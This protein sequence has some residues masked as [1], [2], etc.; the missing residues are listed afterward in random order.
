MRRHEPLDP[1]VERRLD[2]LEA[3]MSGAPHADPVLSALVE[4]VRAVA[5]RPS[6]EARARLD[7]RAEAGFEGGAGRSRRLRPLSPLRLRAGWPPRARSLMPAAGVAAAALIALVVALG[8]GDGAVDRDV[9]GGGAAS[10]PGAVTEVAPADS[11]P[12]RDSAPATKAAPSDQAGG[13]S[14]SAAPAPPSVAPAPGVAA[15][16][17]PVQP[18][19]RR[20]ERSVRLELGARAGRFEAVTDAVVRTTQ[21]AG[22]HV[23]SSGVARDGTRGTASFVLRIP[24]ARVDTAVAVLSRLAHVRSID[25]ATQDL[26]GAFDGTAGRLRDARTQRRALVAAVATASGDDAT[27][28]RGRLAAATA[29]VTRLERAMQALRGRTAY[30]TVDLSVIEARRATAAPGRDGRW[31]PADAW[32]DARRGL[33]IAAGVLIIVLAIGLPIALVG[34][35]ATVAAGALRR[36]RRDAALDAA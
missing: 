28:L 16:A 33:E 36:R 31:T 34:S 23:A 30:A 13:G 5:P 4:D 14:G 3:A 11:G 19:G 18:T 15:P 27:R 8:G 35:L 22:G 25:Q 29:R 17:A 26:T 7:A 2:A 24:S 12:A 1:A 20:V 10:G 21:R 32:D 6:L 9:T